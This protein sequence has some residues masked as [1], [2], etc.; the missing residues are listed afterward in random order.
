MQSKVLND[1]LFM[2]RDGS[3]EESKVIEGTHHIDLARGS[4][5]KAK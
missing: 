3:E 1:D 5:A 2:A 4:D